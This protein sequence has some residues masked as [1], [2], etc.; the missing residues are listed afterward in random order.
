MVPV[1]RDFER[2]YQFNI[3]LMSEAALSLP[4]VLPVL[5]LQHSRARFRAG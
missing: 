2:K 3:L 1:A 5:D 4:D